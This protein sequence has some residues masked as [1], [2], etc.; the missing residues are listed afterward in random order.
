MPDAQR[1]KPSEPRAVR[2]AAG[3][4]PLVALATDSPLDGDVHAL[5]MG[6]ALAMLAAPGRLALALPATSPQLDRARAHLGSNPLG[7]RLIPFRE[8]P[9]E[10]AAHA[11]LVLALPNPRVDGAAER[12]AQA[13]AVLLGWG[14][15]VAASR[16]ADPTDAGA[17]AGANATGVMPLLSELLR[18]RASVTDP[19]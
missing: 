5:V 1:T 6:A 7:L 14:V 13:A 16:G 15:R 2:D 10:V 9:M 4:L 17:I 8:A 19:A 18:S 11:D 3:E 12:V